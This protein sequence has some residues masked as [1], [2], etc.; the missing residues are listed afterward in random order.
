MVSAT[1]ATRT[2]GFLI[3]DGFQILDAAGPI[4]VFEMPTRGMAPP[5]YTLTVYSLDG[6]PVRASCGALMMSER[7]PKGL[8][9]D[10]LI[11]S[12]GEGTRTA[13]TD[14]RMMEVLRA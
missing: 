5:P 6:G 1:P 10:T 3:F 7:L 9:L 4:G 2:I 13:M 8:K 12:G 11:V 14:D